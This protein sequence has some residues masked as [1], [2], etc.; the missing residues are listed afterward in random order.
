MPQV[1]TFF[2]I[3]T[4][5]SLGDYPASL[6]AAEEHESGRCRSA[7]ALS[8]LFDPRPNSPIIARSLKFE[9]ND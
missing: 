1:Q 2:Q 9:V 7:H 5:C 3:N 8:N 6:R 4:A